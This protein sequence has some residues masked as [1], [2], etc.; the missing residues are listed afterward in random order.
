MMNTCRTLCL[1]MVWVLVLAG[2]TFGDA[3]GS[4]EAVAFHSQ[5][6]V[7]SVDR[8]ESA[9][10][11]A[12]DLKVM[13]DNKPKR[14]KMSVVANLT[15]DERS[16][17]VPAQP[18]GL[19]RSVR[20]YDKAAAA[21]RVGDTASKPT[22]SD[23]R[24]L[25]AVAIEG[26]AVT[27]FC[28][29]GPLTR[30][31]LDL[32]DLVGNSLLMD[33]LLPSG[34]VKVGDSWKLDSDLMAALLGLDAVSQAEVASTLLTVTEE[35]ARFEINGRVSGAVGGVSTEIELK[36]KYHFDRKANRVSWFGLLVREN[37]S[38][39]HV[40]PG[41]EVIARLQ[42]K[43]V[44]NA[45]SAA[46]ADAAIAQLP[47][48][49][50]PELTRL[51]YQSPQGGWQFLHERRWYVTADEA[52]L[53]VLRLVDRGEFVAQCKVSSLPNAVPGKEVTLAAFQEDIKRGLGKS[54]KQFV[55]AGQSASDLDYRMYRV[56]VDGEASELPIRWIYYY[57]ADKHGRQVVFAFT[58]E[59]RLLSAFG[60]ADEQLLATLRLADPK[61]AAKP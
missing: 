28:P 27:L 10:E 53:A 25:I 12:G 42:V 36:A 44:P 50:S 51:T 39:G 11:V 57:V 38:I 24:R 18:G 33:R 43:I 15:Y 48:T 2:S 3:A 60:K 7:G 54:F 5:R 29:H 47:L 34:A 58:I 61:V 17:E 59:G 37:R 49:P 16:L 31:E 41:L 55:E 21:L 20:Y 4:P 30:D 19:W 8:V 56:V 26:P 23:Q 32:I 40:G 14:L 45:S 22:L 9:L 13:E 52:S 46:L 1:G 6:A 35:R